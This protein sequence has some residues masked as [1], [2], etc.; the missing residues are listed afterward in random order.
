MAISKKATIR[1]LALGLVVFSAEVL[2]YSQHLSTTR[3]SQEVPLSVMILDRVGLAGMVLAMI[4]FCCVPFVK[5]RP[6][7]IS[8][9]EPKK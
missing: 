5:E 4:M 1:F 9:K 3:E 6:R 8:P 2:T 7:K